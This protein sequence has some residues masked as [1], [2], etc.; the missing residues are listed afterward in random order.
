MHSIPPLSIA[1]LP[2]LAYTHIRKH[3]F[4]SQ[5]IALLLAPTTLTVPTESFSCAEKQRMALFL[6]KEDK[7]SFTVSHFLKRMAC[8][9]LSGKT[10]QELSFTEDAFGKPHLALSE[11]SI[12]FNISHCEA[13]CGIAIST[14]QPVGFDIQ[15][16][17]FAQDFPLK[18]LV[19]PHDCILPQ[20]AAEL[21]LL[22]S[23]KEAVVKA[24]GIGLRTALQ[25]ICIQKSPAM[26]I[27]CVSLLN[28]QW[29]VH[30]WNFANT[31]TLALATRSPQEIAFYTVQ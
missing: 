1:N 10:P 14:A 27:F 7:E 19:H 26:G 11:T 5:K 4:D 9:A 6:K 17:I 18:N 22:W 16:H 12:Q 30:A 3:V 24:Q 8:S 20:S 15:N 25:E 2:A 29:Y 13:W 21:S 31:H 28:T 23:I